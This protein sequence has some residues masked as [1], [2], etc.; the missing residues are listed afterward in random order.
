MVF[1]AGFW[2]FVPQTDSHRLCAKSGTGHLLPL[3]KNAAGLGR[4]NQNKPP[5]V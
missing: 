5:Y 1:L 4:D 2:E 3:L